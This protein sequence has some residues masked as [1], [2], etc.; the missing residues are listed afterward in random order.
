M[1]S[2]VT[3]YGALREALAGVPESVLRSEEK[4]WY[5]AMISKIYIEDRDVDDLRTSQIRLMEDFSNLLFSVKTRVHLMEKH[6]APIKKKFLDDETAKAASGKIRLT[7]DDKATLVEADP[8]CSDIASQIEFGK[9]VCGTIQDQ[10]VVLKARNQVV[11]EASFDN[12]KL[13]TLTD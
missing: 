10:L 8:V 7:I 11:L 12:R 4:D 3:P 5:L 2:S 1:S 6:F 9:I 13:A